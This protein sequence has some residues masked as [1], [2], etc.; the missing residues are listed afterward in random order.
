[1]RTEMEIKER[2]AYYQGVLD[3]VVQ[4]GDD[5]S[6]YVQHLKTKNASIVAELKWILNEE[7]EVGNENN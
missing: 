6:T 4:A 3:G 5:T 2:L 7:C 1:M